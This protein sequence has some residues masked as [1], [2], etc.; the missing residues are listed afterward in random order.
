MCVNQFLHLVMISSLP[1]FL[2]I[3]WF[4]THAF[5]EYLNL[6][7]LNN[8]FK[9]KEYIAYKQQ[10]PLIEYPDFLL[11]KYNTFLTRLLTCPFCLNFWLCLLTSILFGNLNIIYVSSLYILSL[12]IYFIMCRLS[13]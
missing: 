1:S 8:F 7:K 12:A 3:V 10:N 2:L 9:I 4:K 6:F 13:I 11:L 5:V